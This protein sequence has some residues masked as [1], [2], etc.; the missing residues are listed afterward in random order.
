[1]KRRLRRLGLIVG[2]ACVV[3]FGIRYALRLKRE[4]G[5]EA[6]LHSY[7]ETLTVGMTRGTVETFLK[8]KGV[9]FFQA[10]EDSRWNDYI[11][12]GEESPPLFCSALGVFVVL[13]FGRH[14]SGPNLV[15]ASDG[16]IL[17]EIRL[18][19]AAGGCL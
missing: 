4:A 10:G 3:G 7:Q 13:E 9:G 14:P 12:I 17:S 8:S 19:H 11:K 6:T 1:M 2:V 18:S 5:Y 15:R 16:D